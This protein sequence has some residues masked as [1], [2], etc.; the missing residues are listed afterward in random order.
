MLLRVSAQS[1][2]EEVELTGV[3]EGAE[4]VDERIPAGKELTAFADA[5]VEGDQATLD[6]ARTDLLAAV[7]PEQFVDAAGVVGNFERMVRIADGI[8]ISLDPNFTDVTADMREDLG[9]N[10][11]A[12]AVHTLGNQ[13]V[14]TE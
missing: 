8:G 10:E 9:L 7:S 6:A 4:S 5:V 3:V 11:F 14:T 2:G 1:I 13:K 12:S